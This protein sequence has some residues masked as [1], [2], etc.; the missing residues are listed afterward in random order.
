MDN[1]SNKNFTHFTDTIC[2]AMWLYA[3]ELKKAIA[4]DGNVAEENEKHIFVDPIVGELCE[5]IKHN[6]I[7]YDLVKSAIDQANDVTKK[8]IKEE[9]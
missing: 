9:E 3:E 1:N 2:N 6:S 7:V 4:L 8:V 5:S